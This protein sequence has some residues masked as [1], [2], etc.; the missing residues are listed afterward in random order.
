V[1]KELINLWVM[2][3][4]FAIP[5]G[6]PNYE[7]RSRFT[8]A[9]D[10]QIWSL[11]PHMHYRGKDFTYTLTYPDGTE[12]ELLKVSK[13]DFNWQTAYDFVE[14]LS[15]PAGTRI[16]C[17]AHWDNSADN[18]ANPDPT[19]TV[20]FGNESYDEMMIG[21]VDYTVDEGRRPKKA[22]SPVIAKLAELAG[23]FPGEVFRVMIQQGPGGAQETAVYVPHEGDGGWFISMGAIVVSAPIRE[24]AWTGNTFTANAYVPGQ[25]AMALEGTVDGD[26]LSVLI[27]TPNGSDTITGT[28][29]R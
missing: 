23:E 11:A 15:V 13:Y 24:I 5:A 29:E 6:D 28:L 4:Q 7:A 9:Q 25:A 1:D 18:P 21:F 16:D 19:K 12:K 17:V 2:N 26:D 22:E 8:F 27:K 10:S 3:A 20:T 14:P